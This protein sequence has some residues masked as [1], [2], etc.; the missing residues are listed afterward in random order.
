MLAAGEA[1]YRASSPE[2]AV[3]EW[4]DRVMDSSLLIEDTTGADYVVAEDALPTIPPPRAGWVRWI[5]RRAR[6]LKS[7]R[8]ALGRR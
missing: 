8:R 3:S 2:H 5:R 7:L 4:R 6:P 1:D